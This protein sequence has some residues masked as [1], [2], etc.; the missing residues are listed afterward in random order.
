MA[1]DRVNTNLLLRKLSSWCWVHS[2]EVPQAFFQPRTAH[3]I[4]QGWRSRPHKIRNQVFEGAVLG[5]P[6]WNVFFAGVANV[7][8]NAG[9]AE[10][11]FADDLTCER[12]YANRV[13]NADIIADMYQCQAKVHQWGRANRVRFD[14]T[15]EEMKVMHP[16]FEEVDDFK[17]LARALTQSSAWKAKSRA[18][19]RNAA[20][21]FEHFYV[22]V[23]FIRFVN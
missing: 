19:L 1:F 23:A 10:D 3:V 11:L 4:V 9:F 5:P 8:R 7:V 14:P 16:V 18:L 22:F 6:S 12:E 17:Y 20:R 15:K 13:A 21:R 2:F